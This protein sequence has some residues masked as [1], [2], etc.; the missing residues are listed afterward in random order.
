MN[1]TLLEKD[2]Q[3]AFVEWLELK[4]IKFT[5]PAQ[6]T[7]TKSFKQK[8]HNYNMGVRKGLPDL[9]IYLSKE[10]SNVGRSVLIFIEM[11]RKKGGVTS[12]EQQEWIDALNLVVDVEA[13][14]CK[15]AEEAISTISNLLNKLYE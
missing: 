6:S 4:N 12:K 7:F 2:E 15:G 13:K 9:I 11:K 10:Q 5:A 3:I 1:L 14:I 8:R